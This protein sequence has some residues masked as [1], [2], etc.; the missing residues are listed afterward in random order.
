MKILILG[1][2]VFLG[3]HF[4]D[5]ALAAGHEITMFNRG[6]SNPDLYPELEKIVG[7]RD[8]GLEVL[9]G[10]RWDVVVDPSGYVPRLVGAS[11]R[12]LADAVDYYIF[13][14]T[15]SVYS[16]FSTPN[17][18]ESG[19]LGTME[20]ETREEVMQF[21]GPLKVLCEKAA[22]EAM[23]GRVLH[24][25]AGLIVGPHDPTDRFTYWPVRIQKGGE[26]L[27]PV[28]P[29]Y[30][31]QF[32]HA[33]DIADW[34]LKMAEKR[35]GGIYNVT[36]TVVPLGELLETSRQVS[37]SDATIHYAD[38]AFLTE[39]EVGPWMEMP[40]WMPEAMAGMLQVNVDK[41][42]SDGL[43]FRP[44]EQTIRE[45]LEWNATRPA[46]RP[47][48]ASGEPRPKTGLDPQKEARL[49]DAL[50]ARA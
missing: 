32:I 35:K 41:A 2:T 6:K 25:R 11:A 44:L 30:A 29:H 43:T 37:G 16:D 19:P 5:S 17:M 26:V 18:D 13:I 8:G 20:D 38:E 40:L 3:R 24:V 31:T 15:I 7:D 34:S 46:E 28:G 4:I 12:M 23:P 50:K 1:G 42:L 9:K 48:T 39:N 10:R 33:S 45:T 49:I 27:A 14:S 21:Y 36:G 22:E 47:L